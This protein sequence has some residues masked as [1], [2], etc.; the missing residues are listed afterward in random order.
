MKRAKKLHW[1]ERELRDY[2][3]EDCNCTEK[4]AKE[5]IKKYSDCD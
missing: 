5:L 1:S 3:M 2:V 4:E